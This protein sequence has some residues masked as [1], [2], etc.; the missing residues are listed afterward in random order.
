MDSV[1]PMFCI[2]L[3][4]SST[5]SSSVVPSREEKFRAKEK[6]QMASSIQSPRLLDLIIR[7]YTVKLFDEGSFNTGVLSKVHLPANLSGIEVETVRFRCGSLRRYGGRVDEF[8]IGKGVTINPFVERVILIKQE[9]GLNWS[10]IYYSTYNLDGYVLVTPILGLLAYN[11]G[12]D[13]QNASTP[14]PFGLD[15]VASE[16]PIRIYFTNVTRL[17][18]ISG[19]MPYCAY[20]EGQ[21]KVTLASMVAPNVCEAKKLGHLGLVIK[22]TGLSDAPNQYTKKMS[23]WKVAL[24]SSIG[25]A[26]G[27]FLLGLLLIAMFVKAKKR[28]KL[29]EMVRRA[30][31]EEALQVSMVGHTQKTIKRPLVDHYI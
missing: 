13:D 2:L 19:K 1:S 27:A 21:G 26:L 30:Y 10:S 25:A 7:D 3:L 5:L 24:V 29:E 9:L 22:D 16:I 18:G 23:R 6:E 11:G 8:H 15:I 20:F 4:I 14:N 31:E 28:S 12:N 17:K